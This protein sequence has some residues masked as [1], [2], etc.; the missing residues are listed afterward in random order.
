ML[1]T[2]EYAYILIVFLLVHLSEILLLGNHVA[3]LFW[4][5]ASVHGFVTFMRDGLSKYYYLRTIYS[6]TH[7]LIF[8]ILALLVGTYVPIIGI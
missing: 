2:V 4:G 3:L 8:R 7:S 1:R 6:Q 5:L